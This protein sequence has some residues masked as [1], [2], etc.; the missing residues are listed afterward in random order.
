MG[1][2]KTVFGWT[3]S[4]AIIFACFISHF[5]GFARL[6]SYK[7]DSRR[8][9]QK[10]HLAKMVQYVLLHQREIAAFFH[11]HSMVSVKS[12]HVVLTFAAGA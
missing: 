6:S 3:I 1:I 8:H 5:A 4:R 7:Y 9:L 12:W 11:F 10:G 2:K